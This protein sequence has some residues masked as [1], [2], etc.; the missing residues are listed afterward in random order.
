M[1]W[2]LLYFCAH[3]APPHPLL[4][5]HSW[6]PYIFAHLLAL[7]PPCSTRVSL[8]PLSIYSVAR[9]PPQLWKLCADLWSRFGRLLSW[10]GSLANNSSAL[11]PNH[12]FFG[13][14]RNEELRFVSRNFILRRLQKFVSAAMQNVANLNVAPCD[15]ILNMMSQT[16]HVAKPN[17]FL[18]TNRG[19]S[20][21]MR[22]ACY[23]T[24]FTV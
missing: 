21:L 7:R 18:E 9:T 22:K 19:S 1:S 13:H 2:D 12:V 8:D 14:S 10:K 5:P 23:A 6:E 16:G 4:D 11:P 17:M 3:C 15:M 24:M 20:A